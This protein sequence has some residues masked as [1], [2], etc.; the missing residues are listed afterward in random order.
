MQYVHIFS[1]FHYSPI[2]CQV[3]VIVYCNSWI[4]L[5]ILRLNWDYE[6]LKISK[7]PK[8]V[9]QRVRVHPMH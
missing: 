7:H 2:N 4:Y 5:S 9:A 6:D 8:I 1:V 3:K